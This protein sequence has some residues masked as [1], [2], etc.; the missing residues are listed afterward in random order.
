MP[1]CERRLFLEPLENQETL[2]NVAAEITFAF[3]MTL[4][5]SERCTRGLL[6]RALGQVDV[7][8]MMAL[9]R[10]LMPT[11]NQYGEADVH[12]G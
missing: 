3:Q 10:H 2:E 7:T 5:R 11:E 8:L 1:K 4:L 12:R 6:A 9:R